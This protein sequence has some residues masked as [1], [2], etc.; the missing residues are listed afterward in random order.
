M[1]ADTQAIDAVVFDLGG[2]LV[3]WN[4]R[5]LYRK[6]FV[7][8]EAAMETFLKDV[9]NMAWNERQDRGRSWAEAVS[10]AIAHHPAHESYIRAYHERWDEMLN[11]ALD[12][13]VQVLEELHGAGVR[14]LALTNWSA[15]TFHHAE[16]RFDFLKK[17]EGILVSGQEGLMKPEPEIFQ[18]LVSRYDLN[19]S[20]TVF[21][22]DVQKK[23]D[24]AI[25]Q[26]LR[27]V[28]FTSAVQLREDL[29][30]LGL[31]VGPLGS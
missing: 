21:V 29:G 7:N 6:L 10:E 18:L 14:L 26:G 31:P 16:A 20:R 5:H 2:V 4:P 23:V 22:D 28:R 11:G 27:A 24:A 13:T 17:F 9:C 30:R 12:D 8:D 25:A 15:E 19:P 3:D 1:Q